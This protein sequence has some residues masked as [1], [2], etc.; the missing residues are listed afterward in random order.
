MLWSRAVALGT[1]AGYNKVI[2]NR[3]GHL[4]QNFELFSPLVEVDESV[5]DG[6][7]DRRVDHRQVR[8]EG[9]QVGD[10]SVADRLKHQRHL[11]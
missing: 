8:Q 5:G 2:K 1:W 4:R 9:P 6:V 3:N 7:A 11:G 10:R